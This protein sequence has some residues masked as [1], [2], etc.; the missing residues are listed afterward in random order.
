MILALCFDCTH[1]LLTAVRDLLCRGLVDIVTEALAK[2]CD[3]HL[4]G[5]GHGVRGPDLRRGT[6]ASHE[7]GAVNC[8]RAALLH[9]LSPVP[10][11]A[12][13]LG[14]LRFLADPS[15]LHIIGNRMDQKSLRKQLR[16]IKVGPDNVKTLMT[17]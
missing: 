8:L 1:E 12:T 3:G 17:L 15:Q 5:D 2:D 13:W 14:W 10:Q 11:S 7:S 4:R 6:N 16:Q 9:A